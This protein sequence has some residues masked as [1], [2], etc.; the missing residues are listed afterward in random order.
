MKLSYLGSLTAATVIAKLADTWLRAQSVRL[1]ATATALWA[2]IG[3][4]VCNLPTEIVMQAD[5]MM[6]VALAGLAQGEF[7]TIASLPNAAEAG[8]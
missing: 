5:E 7:V 8:I 1:G 3:I 2:K 6:D 4:A